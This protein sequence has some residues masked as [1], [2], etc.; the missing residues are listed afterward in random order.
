[1]AYEKTNWQTGDTVTAEKLNHAEQ[2][3]A[4]AGQV[5]VIEINPE[6]VTLQSTWQEIYDAFNAGVLLLVIN[7]TNTGETAFNESNYIVSQV[8]LADGDYYL[9]LF[10][11]STVDIFKTDSASGYPVY[12]D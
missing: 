9:H 6:T 8:G 4:D 10:N 2:G 11:W 12:S 3:I 1:M 7:H 5:M